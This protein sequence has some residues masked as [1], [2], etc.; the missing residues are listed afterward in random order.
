MAKI[1]VIGTG[2]VGLVTGTCFADM[3]NQVIC[4]D[5]N[6]H[7]IE[8][9]KNGVMPIY[10]PGLKQIVE[11]NMGA[12]RLTF[13]TSY[14]EALK[15]AE[16][17]FIAVGTPSSEDG[18]ADMQYVKQAVDSISE[19]LDHAVIIVNKSTVPVGTGDWVAKI[20]LDQNGHDAPTFSVVSNPE[21]LREG[22]AV[23][24]FMQ[25]DRVVLGS[26]DPDA[27][28]KVAELYEPLRSPILITDLRTAEM[29]KYASNAFLAT[30]I[31][32]INEMANICESLGAD[33]REVAR[34]MGM[35]K[36]IGPSFLDAG[37]GWGGSCFPKDVKALTHMADTRGAHPQLLQ[38]VMDINRNQRSRTVEK[39]EEALGGL[40]DQTIGI[41]GLSFKPNTDDTRDAPALDII[42]MLLEKGAKVQAFDPQAMQ[43]C[44]DEIPALSLRQNPYEVAKGADAILLA[45]EWN[46][47]KSLNFSEI[48]NNMRGNVIFDGRN[49]WDGQVLHNLGFTYFGIGVPSP[50]NKE[51]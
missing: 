50:K 1:S 48:K 17:A 35:D 29:I 20:I 32:F 8:Q 51:K 34:G 13:T 46:E 12:E 4:L 33:V 18:E 3:G 14:P 16:F 9:L 5:I 27:A 24:D 7:R 42:R 30:R 28:N 43:T 15:D 2:Y 40:K 38:A 44:K 11:E 45:T 25:P 39:L 10:E 49:L 36:R 22:S 19:N 41:L 37:L 31:S 47:F 26:T 21:F 6:E 23:N